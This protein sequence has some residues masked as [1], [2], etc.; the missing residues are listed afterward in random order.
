MSIKAIETR[1]RGYR[2]RSRREARWAVFFD[3]LTV[4]FRYEEQGF[5]VDGIPY[6]PDF[7][8]YPETDLATWFEVKGKFPEKDELAKTEALARNTGITAYLYFGPCE[9]PGAGLSR[10]RTLEEFFEPLREEPVWSDEYGW[11]AGW[12]YPKGFKW[13]ADLIPTA[14]RFGPKGLAGRGS[15]FWWWTDCPVCGKAVLKLEGQ[16]GHCPSVSADED[17]IDYPNFAHE[18][19]RLQAAY[20]AAR[21]ARFEHGEEG[22]A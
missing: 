4:P 21:S 18:T 12:T 16:V 7:L 9:Q 19:P 1:Y 2:F 15:N 17:R 8:L 14:F 3:A 11:T 13:Q 22:A 10:I 5:V 6:L 20:E